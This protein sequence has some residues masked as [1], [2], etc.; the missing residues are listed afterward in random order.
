[1]SCEGSWR[2]PAPKLFAAQAAE[3]PGKQ[4]SPQKKKTKTLYELT[5]CNE[6][7][8]SHIT[9]GAG[10]GTFLHQST[11]FYQKRYSST[12]I[13]S[14]LA[15]SEILLSTLTRFLDH[16]AFNKVTM[17]FYCYQ[18][19]TFNF[20]QVRLIAA[21][22][23]HSSLFQANGGYGKRRGQRDVLAAASHNPHWPGT[24]NRSQWELRSAEPADVAGTFE[25]LALNAWFCTNEGKVRRAIEYSENRSKFLMP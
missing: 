4:A 12:L 17:C 15:Y 25:N 20:Y 18:L 1:M 3:K 8:S 23:G 9:R 5:L 14:M 13:I 7:F 24:V 16:R 21:P 10:P 19:V 11:D 2:A 22:T 6:L